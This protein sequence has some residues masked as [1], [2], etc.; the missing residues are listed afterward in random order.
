MH[1]TADGRKLLVLHGDAFDGVVRYARWLALL[2][3]GAY[4]LVLQLNHYFNVIRRRFG[5]PYWSL[6]AYLK[7]R[8]KN[9]VEFVS[10]FADAIADEAQKRDVDGVVCGHIHHAEIRSIG[11]VLYC[12]DGDW[13]ESC[14][15]LV[16]HVDGRLEITPL[17][18]AAR[19]RSARRT[20]L[21]GARTGDGGRGRDVRITL[22]SDAWA[23]QINGVVRTLTMLMR[24]LGLRG[25]EVV[26]H[27]PGP[28]PH[29]ALPDISRDPPRAAPGPA[30]RRAD[31]GGA[32][33]RHPHR[34]RG[35]ARHRRAALLP[36]A[37]L[38]L[39]HR[40]P[41]ALSRICRG[42]L[43][44]AA[45]WSYALLRRFHAPSKGVMVATETVH[46]ELAARGF[47]NLR[48]WSRGVDTEAVRS[49]AARAIS[50]TSSG[51]SFSPSAGS[52][53][54]RTVAAFLA[55]DLPGSKVVVGDGP[56]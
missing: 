8:V 22:V 53:W 1:V 23:P 19:A 13:V 40:V 39:H 26:A 30:R 6:S 17:G 44:G 20:R 12:N 50:P 7:S 41:H 16:E 25:H 37:R 35:T 24:E 54:R 45:S 36:R 9:A 47:A 3:D 52:R 51:R 10:N 38:R 56:T 48:R 5:Y 43:L 4:T 46:T 18:R 34:H 32:A 49:R 42:A 11:G 33:R 31:R 28:L 15:A 27:H 55:L 14:T 21:E 29:H 2:G